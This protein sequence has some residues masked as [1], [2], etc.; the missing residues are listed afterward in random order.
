PAPSSL[1]IKVTEVVSARTQAWAI[2]GALQGNW[3]VSA[4]GGLATSA[5]P[6]L[7]FCPTS[8]NGDSNTMVN[9]K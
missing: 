6:D 8:R 9:A 1:G 7:W 2:C 4:A 3:I 5:S